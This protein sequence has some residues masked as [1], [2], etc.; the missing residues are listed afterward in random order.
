MNTAYLK[1]SDEYFLMH[2]FLRFCCCWPDQI[3]SLVNSLLHPF[4]RC[5]WPGC[6]GSCTESREFTYFNGE[7]SWRPLARTISGRICI[8]CG[9]Y[10]DWVTMGIGRTHH[11]SPSKRFCVK[12]VSKD[13]TSISRC[14]FVHRSVCICVCPVCDTV[15]TRDQVCCRLRT[16]EYMKGRTEGK[17]N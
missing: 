2:I 14:S 9:H 1:Q 17:R 11:S 4:V 5:A 12:T 6:L 13:T 16:P 8:S 3:L 10:K 15:G 7:V